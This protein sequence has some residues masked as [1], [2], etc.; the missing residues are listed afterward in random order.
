MRIKNYQ[1]KYII[2]L[3]SLLTLKGKQSRMR[4]RFIKP[5][6]LHYQEN[7]LNELSK[8]AEDYA[9]RDENKEVVY[10]NKQQNLISMQPEYFT[11]EQ[12][13]LNEEHIIELNEFNK[14]TL[15]SISEIMLEGNFDVK[16]EIAEIYDE[17]CEQFEQ[18]IKYYEDIESAEE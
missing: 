1:I 6:T 5:L 3:L 14:M 16:G 4:T 18:V 17:W 9:E 7:V 11:E 8:L 12:I 2:E 13:L 15:L 10:A